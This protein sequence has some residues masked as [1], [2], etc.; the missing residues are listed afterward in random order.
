MNN[1]ITSITKGISE[2]FGGFPCITNS[3]KKIEK[4]PEKTDLEKQL[5][6][7]AK[8]RSFPFSFIKSQDDML[9]KI[10]KDLHLPQLIDC[11]SSSNKPKYREILKQIETSDFVEGMKILGYLKLKWGKEFEGLS[12]LDLPEKKITIIDM[13]KLQNPDQP[14]KTQYIPITKDVP[15]KKTQYIR[16]SPEF[17]ETLKE[18]ALKLEDFASA[19]NKHN[20]NKIKEIDNYLFN[21]FQVHLIDLI[22]ISS[23]SDKTS[24]PFVPK[25]EIYDL[26][27]KPGFID[28][29]KELSSLDI[30]WSAIKLQ[31]SYYPE[32][33]NL[34]SR[35][36]H[37]G[38]YKT[39][40]YY[41]N[42]EFYTKNYIGPIPSG[43]FNEPLSI[44]DFACEKGKL[45]IAKCLQKS[46]ENQKDYEY[47]KKE[48]TS[49]STLPKC[50][51]VRNTFSLS[52]AR[53]HY[54]Y[55][56]DSKMNKYLEYISNSK[57]G[58]KVIEKL[59]KDLFSNPQEHS[60]N[61]Q[62]LMIFYQ[63]TE[64]EYRSIFYK[65][66]TLQYD[67]H[68]LSNYCL[69]S[70]PISLGACAARQKNL[71]C[72]KALIK[73]GFNINKELYYG[74]NKEKTKQTPLQQAVRSKDI[75]IVKFLIAEGA[76]TKSA[77]EYA[78]SRTGK[79]KDQEIIKILEEEEKHNPSS[80]TKKRTQLE[81]E[82][83]TDTEEETEKESSSFFGN[84]I[85]KVSS[86]C[87]IL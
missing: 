36:N 24:S 56:K 19:S 63:L 38:V 17:V 44:L 73:E 23:S 11:S 55:N 28:I 16:I 69:G 22:A 29:L 27:E 51:F 80:N 49:Y 66:K 33:C 75:E 76:Y 52:F 70:G 43:Y 59:K 13:T 82:E 7:I 53:I 58:K 10:Y 9:C 46:I 39:K 15:K 6:T 47:R 86:N 77:L 26:I 37:P 41:S 20:I 34:S 12:I 32:S 78:K 4:E 14:K 65:L 87:E 1:D 61:I 21:K 83:R 74:Y 25:F 79:D 68:K 85:N 67:L 71:N 62:Y 54:K 48:Y 50:E 72:L 18:K 3:Y 57:E 8:L 42:K 60:D 30:D 5:G 45:E 64:D 31:F 35:I 81:I 40:H 2:Q 84:I